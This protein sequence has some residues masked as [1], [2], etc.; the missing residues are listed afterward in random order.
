MKNFMYNSMSNMISFFRLLG[1]L[2]II[3]RLVLDRNLIAE[4]RE[5]VAQEE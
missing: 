4:M 5:A 2:C 1:G 3:I